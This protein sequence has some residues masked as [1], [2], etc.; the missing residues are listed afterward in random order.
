MVIILLLMMAPLSFNYS[1]VWLI[2]PLTLMGH[3]VL[4]APAGSAPRRLVVGAI[5]LSLGLL[6]LSIPMPMTAQAYG[7]VFFSGL[8]LWLVLGVALKRGWSH[9]LD[10]TPRP[11]VGCHVVVSNGV[12][13]VP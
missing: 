5:A 10:D 11:A 13:L 12:P 7:N 1:Y 2:F 8:V 4:S 6:A 9:A 3:L